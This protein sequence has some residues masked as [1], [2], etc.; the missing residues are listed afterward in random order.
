MMGESG[1]RRQLITEE[2][3]DRLYADLTAAAGRGALHMSV[4]MFGVIAHR[5]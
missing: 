4:T 1:V 5:A 2:Q 3:R